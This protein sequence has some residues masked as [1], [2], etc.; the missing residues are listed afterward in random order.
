MAS[1]QKILIANR[2]EIA[3]RI[4]QTAHDMGIQTVAVY[5]DADALA[6]HVRLADEA[7][8]IGAGPVGESYLLGDKIIAAAQSSGADAIHPGYGF[9]SEN[10]DFAEAVLQAGLIFIGPSAD[11]IALMGNKSAAKIRMIDA[12]IPC[13][14]G[15][16]GDDQSDKKLKAEADKIGYPVM[17]KAAAGGG[18]RGMRLVNDAK[19]MKDA[20]ALARSEAENAFGS[21]ELILEKAVQK[22][23]HVE[24][25][26]FADQHGNVVHLGERDCSVQ[27]RHQKVIE[28]APCPVMTPALRAAMGQSAVDVARAIDYVGAGTVEFL[29]DE[30]GAF[31][32]LEMNTRLQVEHPVTE[33]VTGLDLVEMQIHVA[34]GGVLA[35][36]QDDVQLHGHALEVR[37]YAED[38]ANE[39]LP[40]TG[41]VSQFTPYDHPQIRVDQG[42][43]SGQDISPF[44]DPMVAKIISYGE[45]R[46]AARQLMVTAL[47][48]TV[49]YGPTTNRGFLISCLDQESFKSGVFSTA[50]IDENYGG[51]FHLAEVDF[52][53][54]AR[55]ALVL[56]Q[57]EFFAMQ[58]NAL[59]MAGPL[60]GFLGGEELAAPYVLV[61]G[62]TT[63]PISIKP[64]DAGFDVQSVEHKVHLSLVEAMAYDFEN[65]ISARRFTIRSNQH[66]SVCH[67]RL[68]AGQL[69]ANLDGRDFVVTNTLRQDRAASEAMQTGRI[70]AP[71]HGRVIDVFVST[72]DKVNTGDR[73]AVLEAMKMQHEIF[74]EADGVVREVFVVADQQVGAG[75]MMI[76]LDIEQT[77]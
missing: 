29:L 48:E 56:Y 61:C 33:L 69:F 6:L 36:S 59:H 75:D 77:A 47:K 62:E 7:I 39:F 32:F 63:M 57:L 1:I 60:A 14:P 11:A 50:F 30:D 71:L 22:P 73:L 76:D 10:A 37:L 52:D 18:G 46:E 17:V 51:S 44:Y 4:M 13:V 41:F 15:Y 38:P 42:I 68:G 65:P 58:A 45:T 55:L 31:Y 3:C 40:S 21:A 2:G 43:V 66:S 34:A 20:L 27:R 35:L 9:L 19:E 54:M 8:H 53:Q 72:G 28:E 74:A 16:Q 26:V 67:A 70:D 64:C 12:S 49:L 25:Q 23:R 5:S 24:I